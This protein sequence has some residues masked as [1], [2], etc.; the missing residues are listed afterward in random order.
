[1][2]R[3]TLLALIPLAAIAY[4]AAMALD[5]PILKALAKPLPMLA[6]IVLV[7]LESAGRFRNLV[8]AGFICSLVGDVFLLDKQ[9]HFLLGLVY[10]L[11]AH[12]FYIAAF[13]GQDWKFRPLLF[14]PF[15]L[16]GALIFFTLRPHLG[17]L[18]IPVIV[19]I[20]VI[21]VMCWR[22]AAML[23]GKPGPCSRFALA[24]AAAFMV[25]DAILAFNQ[26]GFPFAA[27]PYLVIATYWLSQYL[28]SRAVRDVN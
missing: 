16:C 4:M 5:V 6:L 18:L 22:A 9:D 26:F 1:M 13:L 27:A 17:D 11:V 15:G 2:S 3:K 23:L 25:S 7:S 21:S 19:Y 10:F 14:L 28:I 12:L 8:L 24:G 20:T